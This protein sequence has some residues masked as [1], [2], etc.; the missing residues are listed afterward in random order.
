MLAR[1][2]I[3]LLCYDD[4]RSINQ[5][6]L[7]EMTELIMQSVPQ[8]RNVVKTVGCMNHQYRVIVRNRRH[9]GKLLKSYHSMYD[10]IHYKLK[11]K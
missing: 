8:E 3:L 5:S 4:S 10:K 11:N 6:S 9:K 7:Q 1:A 2:S